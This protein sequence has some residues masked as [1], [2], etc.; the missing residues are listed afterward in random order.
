MLTLALPLWLVAVPEALPPRRPVPPAAEAVD[1]RYVVTG[2]VAPEPP[3]APAQFRLAVTACNTNDGPRPGQAIDVRFLSDNPPLP[4]V[5]A[6]VQ[7]WLLGHKDGLYL[8]CPG[9]QCQLLPVAPV[10]TVGGGSDA[11]G[12]TTLLTWTMFSTAVVVG[13][14]L[15]VTAARRPRPA[16]PAGA[17]SPSR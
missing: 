17:K 4:P 15:A 12:W 1:A 16:P 14:Y 3:A 13:V 2:R 9:T 11:P 8:I 7:V 6:H 10:G 5:G